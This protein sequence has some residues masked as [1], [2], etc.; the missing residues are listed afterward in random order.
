[1]TAP[2]IVPGIPPANSNPASEFLSAVFEIV[3][4]SAP[5]CII[6]LSSVTSIFLRLSAIFITISLIP[7]SFTKRLLPFPIILKSIF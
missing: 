4:N 1:M 5:A 7:L 3:D 2:P 6:I